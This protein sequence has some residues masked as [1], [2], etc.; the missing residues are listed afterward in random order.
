MHENTCELKVGRLLE[1]RVAKG[2]E[3]PEDVEHMIQRIRA[4]VGQL[5]NDARHVT[6]ADWRMCK[7]LTKAAATR[8]VEMMRGTNP[9]TERSVLVH[10]ESS[11]T[12]VMQFLRIVR[13]AEN[14]HRRLF[15]ETQAALAWAGEVLN[16]EERRRAQAFLGQSSG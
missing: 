13:E 1:I 10:S 7:I 8:A 12:A 9:R 3:T 4:C 5:P 6:I 16:P 15:N 2:Y 11:P 14:P